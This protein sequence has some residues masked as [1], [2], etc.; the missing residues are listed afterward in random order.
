MKHQIISIRP[1]EKFSEDFINIEPASNFIPEWYRTSKDRM[2]GYNTTLLPKDTSLTTSTYKKCTPF[3][4][5][6][7]IGYM[8]YLTSDVEVTRKEDG[9]I[10]VMWRG[11]RTIITAHSAD[12]WNG[13][14]CPTGYYPFVYKWHN[15]H[16]LD[17]PDGYSLLFTDPINRTDLP[18]KTISGVVD[19]DKYNIQVHFPFFIEKSFV[20]IIP[21]GTPITQIIPIKREPWKRMVLDYEEEYAPRLMEKYLSKIKR[22]YKT[23][24]WQRKEYK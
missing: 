11:G 13:F 16:S 12:Q 4:D 24:Y 20:G 10:F 6:M 8:A 1:M 7:T 3:F 23:S 15:Q 17:I 2:D 9:S 5:A 14:P 18:F 21:A 22:S 19:C